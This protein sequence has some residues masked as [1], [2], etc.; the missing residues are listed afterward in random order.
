MMSMPPAP[1][2]SSA[3]PPSISQMLWLWRRPLTLM[4]KLAATEVGV[5][6]SGRS[7]LTPRPSAARAA[8]LRFSVAISLICSELISVLTTLESA[9][10]ARA[11]AS[12]VTVCVSAPT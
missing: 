6:L 3:S 9:C 4:V 11:S 8:K 12:T 10:T 1:P 7:E 2:R 5:L